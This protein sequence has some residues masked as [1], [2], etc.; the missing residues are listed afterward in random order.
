MPRLKLTIQYDGSA[1]FGWQIQDGLPSVQGALAEALQQI[2]EHDVEIQGA[3]RTDRG[4]HAWGQI[5]H[6]DVE[7]NLDVIK[8][9]GGMN[10]FLPDDIRV[11]DAEKVGEDFHARFSATAR[12]YV[13]RLWNAR[14]MR[15]DLAGH[16]GHMAVPLDMAAIRAAVE[17]LP[18]GEHDFKGFQDAEC[19]SRVSLCDLHHLRWVEEAENLWRL[20]IGANHFL[21]H[22]VRNIMGTLIEIGLGKRPVT[23]LMDV[24]EAQDRRHAGMTFMPDGLYLSKVVY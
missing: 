10:R 4:V 12:H 5:A 14:H 15:P 16:A 11:I 24:I 21:H 1:Y 13:Y 8:Y 6:V 9:I 17:L 23:G 2:V 18:L 3:G 7:K 19:Q 20:E 22:M